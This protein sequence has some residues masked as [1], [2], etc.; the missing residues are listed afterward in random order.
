MKTKYFLPA[1]LL[2]VLLTACSGNAGNTPAKPMVGPSGEQVFTMEVTE[3]GFV[4]NKLEAVAGQPIKLVIT[5]KTE[6]TCA[7]EIVIKDYGIN[8]KLPLN[9]TVEV[10]F[11]PTKPGKIHF[12][13]AMDMITGEIEVK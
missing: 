12:A 11:T 2:V 6:K 5:R 10:T 1:A 3:A 4:P 7:T 9:V 13:C 8:Q